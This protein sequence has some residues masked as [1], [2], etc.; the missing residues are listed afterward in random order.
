MIPFRAPVDDILFSLRAVAGAADLPGWDDTLAGDIIAHF[1]DF[2]EG[3][4]APLDAPGDAQGCRL[5]NGRVHMPDGFKS[6]YAQLA[7]GGWQG[8]S[9]PEAHGGMAA[10]PLVAAAVSEVFSGA[11]MSLQMVCNLV[12]GAI[13]TLMR[14]GTP[15]Q[16]ARYVPPL[17]SGELLAT[18]CLT[19]PQ[20]G[21]DLAA[22]RTRAVPAA[23]GWRITGEKIF[24]SGGD[25]DMSDGI[26]HLVLARTGAADEGV[27][28]LSLFLCPADLADGRNAVTVARIEDK[29]GLH[30]SPTC[31]MVFDAAQAELIGAEGQGLAVMF[32]LMNH[33]RLDVALQGV[34][35]AARAAQI[36][37]AYA[38]ERK[39]GRKPDGSAATLADHADVARMLDEQTRLTIGGRAMCHL[40]LAVGAD[41]TQPA[42]FDFLTPICK[43][44]C[45]EAGIRAADL[46]MQILGGYG[47]LTEYGLGQIWRDARVT[48]IYEGANGIHARG[49]VTRQLKQGTGADDF[50]AMVCAIAGDNADVAVLLD[51]WQRAR[52]MVIAADDPLPLAHDFAQLTAKLYF[53]A[54]WARIVAAS[55]GT[56]QAPGYARLAAGLSGSPFA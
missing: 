18:M 48:A 38:A 43:I 3:V 31:H 52:G 14:F 23:D 22:I 2:A 33:A 46:G 19:E 55:E 9:A 20:A 11:N 6:A 28:G 25:Q 30:A 5:D 29:L 50:A 44:F 17:V 8:L 45:S 34:A 15:D 49:L 32:T 37:Q 53:H 21:S 36:S 4:I 24:I 7:E 12:P 51:R 40:A 56:P 35:K 41:G 26:L 27:K 42:L 1:A 10:H 39:Q 47:Y 13:T 16:Q 54:A